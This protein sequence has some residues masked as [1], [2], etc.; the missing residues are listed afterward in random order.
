MAQA[1]P[2]AINVN[3]PGLIT[4]VN[5]LQD[6]F[7]TVGVQNPI[8]LPQIVVVGS[9]SS[10]KSSVLENIVGRDFLPRGTGIVTRRPL[11][12][13]LI[14]RAPLPKTQANGIPDGDTEIKTT[15]AASNIEE[16]GEFLHI[17]GQK[18]YDFNKIREEIVRETESK[19]GRNAGIS[20]APINLRI[21]SPN[22]LT[23]TLVDLPGL[24]KVPVGDQPRD[25]EKQIREMVMK[26]IS[27]PN[28]I[29]LAVT[30]ANT[31]LAN[32]DGLKLAREVDPE[33]QRTIGVL[34]KVDLMDEGTDV[35]DI[36]AG[37]IIPLRLGYV[38]VVNRG[39]RDIE[40]KKAISAALENERNFFENHKAYRNKASYCGTPYLARKLN[41]ILMM[42]IKQT[43]PDIKA[44]IQASL[45]K[46]SAELT[47]LGSD[48]ML[49]NSANIVL[50]IIT[51][52][53]NEY[54]TVLEG[55]NAELSSVELSGG[56]RISFVYHELY[57]NGVKAVDP[58]DQVKDIDIR[59][60]LYNSSGS[61][62]ALF[63]GTTAF[64]LIV[65]QQIKRLEEPSIKCVSLVYDEL[66]RI[67]GQLLTK[68]LFRRYPSLKERFHG[69]VI[70]FFKKAM[71]PTNKLVRDLVAMESCYINT[72]HP[73]FL[74]GHRAMAIVNEKHQAAKPV[75]VDPKTGKPLPPSAAT[76]QPPR[77]ASPSLD[78]NGSANGE[79]SGFF[80]SFFA[81]K[82][83]KKMAAMEPPPP[84][85]KASGTLSEKE[86]QE[87]E[88]IKLLITSYY[89]I[90]RR[91]MI[92]M[93]PKAIML[94][95]V[96]HT[97]EEMQ[98]ELLEQMYRTQEL[99]DLLKESD[100]TVRRRKECQQM[101]ESLSRASEIV[102]QVQARPSFFDLI[103][104]KDIERLSTA[105]TPPPPPPSAFDRQA[106]AK[107]LRAPPLSLHIGEHHLSA[108]DE[109]HP[110]QVAL[111]PSPELP[112]SPPP[113]YSV[114]VEA[115]TPQTNQAAEANQPPPPPPPPTN[116][117]AMGSKGQDEERQHGSIF[118]VSGPVIVAENMI[119]CA[120]YE[121]CKVGH[122]QLVGEVIR[123]DADKATIQVYE[124]TAGVTVGDP[125]VRTG[126]PLSVE[127]GPGLM[128]TIYDGIQRPLK[129]IS[130]VS[131][132]IYIPRGIDVPSL[133]REKKWDFT[134]SDKFK[135]GD[136]ITGG[137]VWGSVYEN[138]LLYDH[139]ILLP[140][141]ARGTIT[142]MPK[143]GSYT[144]DEKILELE[145]EG[146][147]TE[148]GM[149]H[150]WPVRVPRPTTDK[151]SSQEP[152]IV[153][154]RVLDALFPSVMGGTVCIPGAFGC[155]KT[156][157]SQSVS[158]FSNSDIIVYVGCGERGNEMAEVLM[159]FPELTI[160]VEGRQEP[161]MK[162]TCLIANT[163][164][165][166]VA[167]REASIYTGITVAEYFRDQ[168]K[169]VAMMADSTS[170]WAEALR[171]ISGRLGEM[172]ADQGFPAYLGAKL[173]SFYE[174]A[175]RV[176][177][178]GSPERKGSVSIVGAVSP[179]GGD[180]SD[181]VTSSTLGIV[182]VFWG[183]DKKL[184]QRKHFPSVNTSMSYS[185]YTT[186]LENYY[187][188]EMPEFPRLRDRIRELLSTSEDLDQVVQLVGKSALGDSDKITLDVATL[189]KEDFLQQN[190][191]SEYDQFCPLWKTAWMMRAMMGFHDESQ[192]A[193]Q[194]GQS[195][196][197]V[198]EA[199]A[200]IQNRLRSMKF[201]VP[202]EGEE[203]VG[204]RYEDLMQKMQEK[205]AS[206][207][208]E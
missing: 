124:E 163:S 115:H 91:T 181:P 15:D 48:G 120:M 131:K 85:L 7:T 66:V 50:N 94:N 135:E 151:L 167:A 1:N 173:A 199:T 172:P 105:P 162:R 93:V 138:S 155:G 183:L 19:T 160:T 40:T 90:V 59:T 21:Y 128:E 63:V 49:G 68:P 17:P 205:F 118:S 140:P 189:I 125:V 60:I 12:L 166:P 16:W 67:L 70:S 89:N 84:T 108:D 57:S 185:K 54:R 121:L 20:P 4:L 178:L 170:R 32:S 129:G 41:L 102:S 106:S 109:H 139:K 191:Y 27:K 198:R 14:N 44:R 126:K 47:S 80:G 188:K 100:Y 197:K 75:Q 104:H 111:P 24:T 190:G 119:G 36:L 117:A 92:D 136:H 22:V 8:D 174:R 204:K 5:K 35:V 152:F 133:N 107:K 18:Y 193:I 52:F 195:W 10:G 65:K 144:V 132:S 179:P 156:V 141:R 2:N 201:E 95:L 157:I 184:A 114:A 38:P 187:V 26:Q 200:D 186:T 154:Q 196:V 202:S 82:N 147:K 81:S 165:M 73:D 13:Q 150:Q 169:A 194:Q 43:L 142:R 148:Y 130:D 55:H 149:M 58:F 61:S 159:D 146:K 34:T 127:L 71:D 112:S 137:D 96:E 25:I 122:D 30:A 158:K 206:V 110:V 45:Q 161:I 78:L 175:G 208:D 11:V 113:P 42:H 9:Q 83:K 56:A 77:S 29:I 23:L 176:V 182:Q 6:V 164:N 98:R 180:F 101:V 171:E 87:V 28:A 116:T 145:F 143:K 69:V 168:G 46:Y 31:D 37:R 153:G 79:G 3:D 203:K 99:D 88:V 103:L 39:Q 62:P 51:E 192:K 134:P 86:T 33:G 76:A 177:S 53:S 74:N 207:V 64:E 123:I 72:G 97:K